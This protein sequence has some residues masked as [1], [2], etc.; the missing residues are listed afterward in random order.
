MN[1]P[2]I[3]KMYQMVRVE[4]TIVKFEMPAAPIAISH[5]HH[6]RRANNNLL[7]DPTFTHESSAFGRR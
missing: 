3:L 6:N 1:E 5:T 4:L 7:L 2:A